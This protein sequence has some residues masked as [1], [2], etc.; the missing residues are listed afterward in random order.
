[1]LVFLSVSVS[2]KDANTRHSDLSITSVCQQTG[3]EF[4][5]A[6]KESDHS[7]IMRAQVLEAFNT[8]YKLKDIA[9]PR[10]PEDQDILVHV[11]AASYCHTDAVF[12]SGAMWQDLPSVGSHQF[13]GT[14]VAM[15]LGVS[16]L[17]NLE[18][19]QDLGH[20]GSKVT[21]VDAKSQEAEEVRLSSFGTPESDLDDEKGVDGLLIHLE[22]QRALDFGS[23][24]LKNYS[25][26]VF[27]S[28]FPEKVFTSSFATWSLDI[29]KWWVYWSVEIGNYAQCSTLLPSKV[30]GRRFEYMF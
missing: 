24:L 20:L 7:C 22:S 16:K 19:V 14:I 26:C 11:R 29:P 12:A 9:E 3:R 6:R 17:L 13:A 2:D 15:G 25:T 30:L 18:V 1:M 10:E 21:I 5:A 27:F 28:A 23:K 4:S 8:S